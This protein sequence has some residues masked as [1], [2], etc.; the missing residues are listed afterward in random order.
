[1]SKKPKQQ[2]KPK[3][4]GRRSAGNGKAAKKPTASKK[5]GQTSPFTHDAPQ[6][7]ARSVSQVLGEITW[8]MSQ[9]PTHKTFFI[10]DL[11]WMVMP[12][13]L[14]QQFRLFYD[15]DKPIGVVFWGNVSDAV[16]TRLKAGNAKLQP[17]DWKS[18]NKLWCVEIIAPFG[19]HEVMLQDLKTNLFAEQPVHY[20]KYEGGKMETGVI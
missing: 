2:T 18:G 4:N 1:V 10:S 7:A 6:G 14:L 15:Q 17:A 3:S 16:E 20:L 9:S 12:P 11:E 19:G 13:V 5:P 8:L